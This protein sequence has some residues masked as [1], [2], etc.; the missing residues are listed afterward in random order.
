MAGLEEG[1]FWKCRLLPHER[2]VLMYRVFGFQTGRKCLVLEG[3]G[4]GGWR[5]TGGGV[6]GVSGG[7]GGGIV[8]GGM[9]GGGLA[10]SGEFRDFGRF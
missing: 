2:K 10:S 7:R 3:G 4:M 9:D 6:E 1:G 8:E 5:W